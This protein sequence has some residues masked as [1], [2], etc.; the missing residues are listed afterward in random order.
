MSDRDVVWERE[1][2]IRAV[3][4][5]FERART[6]R[7]GGV[8]FV[9]G[10][11]GLGKTTSLDYARA[12]GAI[13]HSVGVGRGDVMESALPFGLFAQAL[14][15][16]GGQNVLLGTETESGRGGVG[17]SRAARFYGV[18]RWLREA[19]TPLL[20]CLDDLHWADP[21]SLALLTFLCRR[22][23]H[24]PVPL[25]VVGA[26]RPYP[27]A[28][29][30]ACQ[31]L[32]YDRL[33]I[34]ESLTPLSQRGAV[35][36][37]SA[38]LGQDVDTGLAK[39]AWQLAAGNPLLLE[40]LAGAV[41][42]GEDLAAHD[43]AHLVS[44]LLLPR[45]AGLPK[46]GI[47]LARA[48]SVL[49]VRFRP[50]LATRVAG[51]ARGAGE[52][53]ADALWRSGLVAPAEGGMV[54]FVHPLFGQA[55]YE[56]LDA[57]VR[58]RLHAAAFTALC[59]SGREAEAAEHAI[60]AHLVDDPNAVTVLERAGRD[61]LRAGAL[62]TAAGHLRAAVELAGDRADSSLRLVL[63]EA[64]LSG[65]HLSDAVAVYDRLR[66]DSSVS[67]AE[68]GQA[69]R[70]LGRAYSALGE[71]ESA[72]VRFAEA[73]ELAAGH[74]ESGAIEALLDDALASW[75]TVGPGRS[76]P[77]VRRAR[78]LGRFADPPLARR[79][80]VACA[81]IEMMT[82]E[83]DGLAIGEAA[84]RVVEADPLAHLPDLS[85]TWG[86]LSTYG[87]VA[88]LAER[89][90]DARRVFATALHSAEGVGAIEAVAALGVSVAFIEAK[91]SDQLTEALASAQRSARLAEL[92][93]M[94][95]T[96]AGAMQAVFLHKLGR[97]EESDEWCDRV[98]RRALERE[99]RIA[100]L[101]VWDLRGQRALREGRTAD[102]C[103]LYSRVEAL[104]AKA[105]FGDPCVVPWAR[106]AVL[107]YVAGGRTEDALQ[108]L[109]WLDSVAI[110]LPCRWPSIVAAVA[111]AALAE[112]EHDSDGAERHYLNALGLHGEVELPLEYAE[113][114]LAYGAFLRRSGYP[115]RARPVLAEALGIAEGCRAV[116]L[117]EQV[118]EELAVAGGRR[119]STRSR[120][121]TAQEAR[122]ARL[123]AGGLSNTDIAAALS[124]TVRTV[125]YHLGH[126]Y[127]KLG[128]SSRRELM[129]R[130]A[131]LDLASDP[132]SINT[133]Q[134]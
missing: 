83:G 72:A 23:D 88:A 63:G 22:I 70:M 48:G 64:L 103:E 14:E 32:V 102:A 12:V 96:F 53:A 68:R 82:G 84:A 7:R 133:D 78:E 131:Q 109:A 91:G 76:L 11:A 105:G 81:F 3:D 38:R 79:S 10:E 55:L 51:L 106:H 31:S 124:V 116:W 45:F 113:T 107:A 89:F 65:G 112:A 73:V 128:L 75:V 100:L 18:L 122:V 108:V 24:L 34:I 71:Y 41:G 67:I 25:V 26:L 47:R 123:A 119:R 90:T 111:R 85:W 35:R 117:G 6:G 57:P 97:L 110:G 33:A 40:Q 50:E 54:R 28:A 19:T 98:E 93:P 4:G 56:N 15:G 134:R 104:Y 37:L 80:A 99:E 74:D 20:L 121:L 17:G 77:L 21:D 125:E 130:S 2:V 16:L 49:G 126:V 9:M 8:L 30:E 52:L 60:R 58:A 87:V 61:A 39:S 92:V 127:A 101:Q 66:S 69:L 132:S 13:D 44:E 42:R 1:G 59:E 27:P 43:G 5:L 36:L 114:L 29:H 129:R 115:A 118:A 94:I 46:S 95:A 86:V 120:G 62:D